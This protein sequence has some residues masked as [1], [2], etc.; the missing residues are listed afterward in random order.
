MYS[1]LARAPELFVKAAQR[2]GLI[3]DR[4]HDAGHASL[5]MVTH[6]RSNGRTIL[7]KA[8]PED[9]RY[10][11]E[12]IALALWVGGPAVRVLHQADDLGIAAL[13]L[14]GTEPGG[15]APPGAD[16]YSVVADALARLH[17]LGQAPG[18]H[19]PALPRL[20]DFLADEMLPRVRRRMELQGP[21]PPL[22]GAALGQRLVEQLRQDPV[23]AVVLHA[24]I[25][26]ENVLFDRERNPVLAD[27]LP[28]VGDQIFDWA[29]W[30]V[31]YDLGRGTRARFEIAVRTAGLDPRRLR[32][33]SLALC[34]DG[35]L[36]YREVEDD[37]VSVMEH[38]IAGLAGDL[39]LTVVQEWRTT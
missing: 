19:H 23:G 9:K 36:Y 33:W 20:G 11:N 39:G 31:Y 38:V 15:S 24:D 26:R 37:R 1:W 6:E 12:V 21:R 2:W 7:L 4:Y 29:F 27:P 22:D 30:T 35:L 16:E 18:S 34:V 5:L 28:M 8:W 25:Y 3:L 13:E 10:R 32:R 17:A 14:V